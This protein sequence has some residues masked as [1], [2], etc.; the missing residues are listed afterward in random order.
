[1]TKLLT[2]IMSLLCFTSAFADI[3]IGKASWYSVKC[4]GGHHTA[5]GERLN[6]DSFT[7]AHKTL[8]MGTKVRVT[9]LENNKSAIVRINNRGPYISGRIIDVTKVV[10]KQLNFLNKGVTKVKIEVVK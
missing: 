7:A 5:S 9:N 8:K 10:A 6:D 1:M 2:L 4:N 3:Q